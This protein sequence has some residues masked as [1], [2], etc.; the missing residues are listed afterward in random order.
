MQVVQGVM[1]GMPSVC[2][3]IGISGSCTVQTCMFELPEFSVIG[4]RLRKIYTDHAC[5]VRW[6]GLHG[7]NSNL[8][9][10]GQNSYTER[11]IVYLYNE[12]NYCR[13]FYDYNALGTKGRRCDPQGSGSDS[14]QNLCL[15]CGR[16]HTV[17]T[18]VVENLCQCEFAFCCDIECAVCTSEAEYHVCT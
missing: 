17:V 7:E 12:T 13:L 2:K 3:C 18:E 6:N 9:A 1:E 14:C 8:V 5:K 15:D 16:G 4:E 11:D 10:I